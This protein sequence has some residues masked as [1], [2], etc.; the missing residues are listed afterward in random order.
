MPP[1]TFAEEKIISDLYKFIINGTDI[2]WLELRRDGTFELED[3]KRNET[4][5][6]DAASGKVTLTGR[7]A[8]FINL[9]TF[10]RTA[11]T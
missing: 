6:F 9:E 2:S 8:N 1:G 7:S 4:L 3:L 5:S 10:S 11:S